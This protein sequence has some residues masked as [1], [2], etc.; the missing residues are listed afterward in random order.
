MVAD[1]FSSDLHGGRRWCQA[2][3]ACHLGLA[4]AGPAAVRV[5]AGGNGAGGG[6]ARGS[7]TTLGGR[8][9]DQR[10]QRT[11]VEG[12]SGAQG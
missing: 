8:H 9:R 2:A 5:R 7:R 11:G 10:Q 12:A 4:T 1:I 3:R 6:T